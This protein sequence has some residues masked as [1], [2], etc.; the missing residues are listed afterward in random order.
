MPAS[1]HLNLPLNCG[2]Q[3][4]KFRFI[5]LWITQRVQIIKCNEWLVD[6]CVPEKWFPQSKQLWEHRFQGVPTGKD[7]CYTIRIA[8]IKWWKHSFMYEVAKFNESQSQY[9]YKYLL[10]DNTRPSLL[11]VMIFTVQNL[12]GMVNS[13]WQESPA[14]ADKPARRETLPKIAPIR[15]AYNAVADNTG[16]SSF[17]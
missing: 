14:I 10:N 13:F 16:L 2:L 6:S 1:P 7:H 12:P 17:V 4:K 8:R 9:I 11:T 15:R 3:A 5:K